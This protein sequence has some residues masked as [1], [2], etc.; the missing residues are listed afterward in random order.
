MFVSSLFFKI[1]FDVTELIFLNHLKV[2]CILNGF[3]TSKHISM[4][5]EQ[6]VFLHNHNETPQY[7]WTLVAES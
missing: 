3:I 7:L 4:T 5:Q 1:L 2:I 6:G